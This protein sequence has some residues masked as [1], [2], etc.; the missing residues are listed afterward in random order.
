MPEFVRAREAGQ[1]AHDIDQ[2]VEILNT[3]NNGGY[4]NSWLVGDANSGEIARYEQGLLY[5][6]LARK[7]DGYFWGDNAPADPRIR[8]LECHA[9]GFSDVRMPN[10][11]RRV[12]WQQLLSEHDGRIDTEGARRMLGD[13]FDPYLGYVHPSS[14]TICAHSDADPCQ[15]GGPAPFS[16]FGSVDGKIVTSADVESMSLWARFG[17]ADGAEFIAEDF[18]RMH[19]QWNWQRGCLKDR[20]H[21]PWTYIRSDGARKP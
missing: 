11:A 1:Y 12:R 6:D 21:R 10:G 16:P 5:Q 9:T 14:R 8:N 2:W 13:T 3:G 18:L 20:P 19:P 4:A 15:F 17:R 7:T